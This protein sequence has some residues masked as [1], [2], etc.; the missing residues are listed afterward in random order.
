[1]LYTQAD[2][3][4][5]WASSGLP[6]AYTGSAGQ[7]AI[8][9]QGLVQITRAGSCT[10]TANQ[11]G[12]ADYPAATPVTQTFVIIG[13]PT[14][15]IGS[16]SDGQTYT[17][18]Q[19]VPTSFSCGEAPNG[20]GLSSCTDSAGAGG[21]TGTL[22]TT[23]PGTHSYTV[24]AT[25]QDAL[26]GTA[27]IHYTVVSQQ[28]HVDH[29]V[30]SSDPIAL[31]GS[32]GLGGS[33]VVTVMAVDGAGLPVR[34]PAGGMGIFVSL[35]VAGSGTMSPS[36]ASAS[37]GATSITAAGVF[38]PVAAGGVAQVR[39]SFT[40]SSKPVVDASDVLVAA[41]DG[42][43]SKQVVDR[44]AYL[45]PRGTPVDRLRWSPD[46]IAPAGSLGAR[47]SAVATVTAYS[48]HGS[49]IPGAPVGLLLGS[50]NGTSRADGPCGSVGVVPATHKCQAGSD[51]TISVTYHPPD[52]LP[53]AGADALTASANGQLARD[54]YTFG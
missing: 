54:L 36:A 46:P 22:D 30:W 52:T 32:L 14:A 48:S 40:S 8:G 31:G 9:L 18:G 53:N 43:G 35:Q 16:P 2:F 5:A 37:C 7:C 49:P 51:G 4:P 24:T 27:S 23:A 21:G 44:Y 3:S 29:L 12:N 33:A 25:S 47:Q 26:T 45:A 6:I 28:A 50:V 10:V 42:Y 1:V 19:A 20:P 34:A 11:A 17:Q 38:C 13:P 39:V 41:V 15:Q